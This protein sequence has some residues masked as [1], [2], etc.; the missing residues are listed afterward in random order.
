MAD[1]K[2]DRPDEK[3]MPVGGNVHDVISGGERALY[4]E[5]SGHDGDSL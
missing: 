2:C 3:E 1:Q 4:K 5:A